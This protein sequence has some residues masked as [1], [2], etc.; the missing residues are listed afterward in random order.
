MLNSKYIVFDVETTGLPTNYN[1]SPKL[2]NMWPHI[3]QFSWIINDNNNLIEKSY[4]IKPDKYIIPEDSIKIHNI[5]NEE[6]LKN[7]IPIKNV[8]NIFKEDCDKVDYLVA[9]N[10]SFDISVIYAACYRTNSNLSFNKN[11]KV[12]CTMKSTTDLCKLE[13]KNTKYKNYKY[14]KLEELYEF[15]FEK[16]IQGVKLHNSLEDSR[17]TLICYQE[18]LT[19]N[20]KFV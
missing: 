16:K 13:N 5:T 15:L 19:R 20:I 17:I 4:I 11:K 6:A 2:H 10:S 12:L 7:G 3:V 9:H 14:P 1:S 8:L 18:L